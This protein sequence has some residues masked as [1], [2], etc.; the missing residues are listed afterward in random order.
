MKEIW[1]YKHGN[2]VIYPRNANIL[3]GIVTILLFMTLK[4]FLNTRQVYWMKLILLVFLDSS[5]LIC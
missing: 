1:F 5:S 3:A 4:N 2:W